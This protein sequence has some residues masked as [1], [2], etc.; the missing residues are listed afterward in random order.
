MIR[1]YDE[2]AVRT[3]RNTVNL[4]SVLNTLFIMFIVCESMM[5]TILVS[6]IP[7][8]NILGY[9]ML[10]LGL[11]TLLRKKIKLS[12]NLLLIIAYCLFIFAI[13]WIQ[14]YFKDSYLYLIQFLSFGVMGVVGS[15]VRIQPVLIFKNTVF[16]S[17][18][19]L[20]L[21]AIKKDLFASDFDF[22]YAV[23]PGVF[24]ILILIYN[25]HKEKKLGKLI[26]YVML[27]IPIIIMFVLRS[28]RGNIVQLFVFIV[29][30][31]IFLFGYKKLGIGIVILSVI[32][33]NFI[34]PIVEWLYLWMNSRGLTIS[35][36]W[37]TYY[38][39][40]T[41][42]Q[43]FSHGRAELFEVFKEHFNLRT[44][45]LGN[46]V[47]AYE[48]VAGTYT[49]NLFLSALSEFGIIGLVLLILVLVRFYKAI[50]S[51]KSQEKFASREFYLMVFCLSFV[52]LMFSSIYWKTSSFWLLVSFLF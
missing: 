2:Y 5:N 28:S 10:L 41:A 19:F 7:V 32:V 25:S 33:I 4:D 22:G 15:K 50:C 38:L 40:N 18:I 44:F 6:I 31:S 1:E 11:I 52:K 26:S 24:A 13:S 9:A 48:S 51:N 47:G 36:I 35:V 39:F 14:G 45:M 49:H 12:R 17:I 42:G 34:R 8:D 43:S 21:N 16:V 20:V 30:G 27:G 37:K 3:E 46:G 29:L 23:I